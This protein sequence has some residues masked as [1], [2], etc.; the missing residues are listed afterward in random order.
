MD[1]DS[2][3]KQIRKTKGITMAFLN[4]RSLYKNFDEIEIFLSESKV[5]VLLLGETFLNYSVDST[6]LQ[7]TG[8]SLHRFD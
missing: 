5:D 4:I 2:K 8:Y 6:H 7:V 3:A 1:I